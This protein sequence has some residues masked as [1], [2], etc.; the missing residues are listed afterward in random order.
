ELVHVFNQKQSHFLCTHWL[1]E[2]L[3]VDNEG[4]PRPAA[5]MMLLQEYARSGRLLNLANI[6]LA[7]I[8]PRNHDEWTLAYCQAWMYVEYLRQAFGAGSIPGMLQAY[9]EGLETPAAI[10]KVCHRSIADFEGGYR[11]FIQ[12]T[13]AA[14]HLP[15]RHK[16]L[17]LPQLEA[18]HKQK[19]E[20]I[21]VAAELAW[22]LGQR[23]RDDEALALAEDV[24]KRK[25]TQALAAVIKAKSMEDLGDEEGA[26][27]LLDKA[28][29]RRD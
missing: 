23:R 18:R 3:A 26:R 10:H 15:A 11:D 16:P 8:R 13:L 27:A 4:Y 24:L 1:T 25:P 21:D 12:K 14:V 9:A 7:L 17:T 28:L 19:P 22:A 2:G 20:D 6:D 29:D 5:W